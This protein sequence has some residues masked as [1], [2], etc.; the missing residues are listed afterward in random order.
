[1][2]LFGKEN[3][4]LFGAVTM[5][6]FDCDGV[7]ID[8]EPI[9][10]RLLAA[11]AAA[12]GWE[13]SGAE[14]HAVT[15]LTWSALKPWFEARLGRGL[16]EDWARTMQTRLIPMLA[17]EATAVPYA[18]E[19]LEEAR[20]L[21]VP[22]RVASNSSHEEMEQKFTATGL[23]P[24]VRGRLHSARDVA[25][26][27]PAPDL[28]L[29]AAAAEGVPAEECLVV[30]DSAPGVAGAIAAGMRVIAYM[31]PGAPAVLHDRAPHA[32]IGSLRELLP[33]LADR[34]VELA[35]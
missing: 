1:L 4:C 35:R 17:R 27:K 21:G 25:Q 18:R 6:I 14:I 16:P 30:E 15:G 33:V 26:G 28:F 2:V 11:E 24:L 7:L 10:Q 12:L 22:Y 29:A 19:V 31:P 32:T 5:V 8:S 20:R 9:S 23:M 13:M 34:A 3:R